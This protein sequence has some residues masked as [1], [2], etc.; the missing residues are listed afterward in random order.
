M[1][2]LKFADV[3]NL[4]TFLSKPTKSEGFEK[5]IDFL[6]ANPIKY[7]LTVNPIV[8]TA[9]I[10][11]F[12][13]TVEAKIVNGE[14]Q[15]QALVDRKKVI[16]TESTIRSDLQLYDAEG[17]DC[18]P[19]HVIFEQL[20]LMGVGKGFSGRVT[21]L[22]P[23]M[24]VQAQEE[25]DE[26]INEETYDN[27]ERATTTAMSLD[28]EQDRGNISK[29][30]SKVTPNEPGSH[31]TSSDGEPKCQDTI[32]DII[33]QTRSENVSKFFNDP[34]LAGV[35]TSRSKED[36]LTLKEL[37]EL[38]TNL[39]NRVIDLK[40]IKI[41]QALEIDSLKIR[42]KKLRRRRDDDQSL[43]EKDASKQGR[44][45]DL[46]ADEGITLVNVT[47][48]DQGR[49]NDEEMFDTDVLDDEEVF[50]E[51]VDVAG[52]KPKSDKVVTQKPEQGTTTITLTTTVVATTVTAASTIP[53]AKEIV[54]HEQ[55]ETPTPTFY[56]HQ[57]SHVKVQDKGKAKMVEEPVKLKNKGQTDVMKNLLLSYKLKKKNK[58]GLPEKKL[59][60]L[61]RLQAEEQ[62]QLTNAKKAKLF[63]KFLKKRRKFFAGKRA[64]DKRNRPPNKAQQRS[65]M[66]IYLKNMDGWKPKALKNKSFVEIQ[67]I[68]DKA[69]K[70][71]NTFV[72][73]R[74]D[75]V[76]ES[77]KKAQAELT[78][79]ISKK[80]G[81]EFK[82]ER[83]KKQK[84]DDDKESE[85]LKK[86]LEIIPDDEDDVTIDATPLSSK[87]L[88]IVDYKIYK[89][90][91]KS[92]V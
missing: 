15:L 45:A 91:K 8:Y 75:L 57:P 6:N 69:M 70:M 64:K 80:A 42:V 49:I 31:G 1:S 83:S 36:S 90:G 39:Q 86:C 16:I 27:F 19:N 85:E 79:E 10:E 3:H 25:I 11:Q 2:T 65:L 5:I 13:T 52:A 84:V 26:A 88:I 78:Q 59:N 63:M 51:S 24:M 54:L 67:E 4:V 87:S 82:Q 22:F 61:N 43:G 44:I 14:A 20:T 38:C 53:K 50:A 46:D 21:P 56:V 66:C 62:E 28:A 40:T 81:D 71:I 35:N 23:T 76:E 48:E 29:T 72:D 17:V 7:A 77:T 32:G 89:E 73:F 92:Y 33:A 30:Q 34:L 68:F 41:T 47:A 74:T 9:C 60:K 58:K 55:E 12:W 18:L 37:M